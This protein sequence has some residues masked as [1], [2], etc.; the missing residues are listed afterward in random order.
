MNFPHPETYVLICMMPKKILLIL[1]S[2]ER[3]KWKKIFSF[4]PLIGHLYQPFTWPL[5]EVKMKNRWHFW[6]PHNRKPIFKMHD[7][8][9][10]LRV[11]T[12]GERSEV[13]S[14]D[15]LEEEKLMLFLNFQHQKIFFEYC[16]LVWG[17]CHFRYP[18]KMKN[19]C[20]FWNPHSQN[21]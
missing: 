14:D 4:W 18:L 3:S 8:K 6:N 10:I 15:I 2:D 13:I 7:A 19:W 21:K 5:R 17:Q 12:S 20:H 16:P 1:T 11:L 9:I